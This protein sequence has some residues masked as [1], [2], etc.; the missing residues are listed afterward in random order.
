MLVIATAG[1]KFFSLAEALSS[2]AWFHKVI[3]Q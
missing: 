2:S 3:V 1:R